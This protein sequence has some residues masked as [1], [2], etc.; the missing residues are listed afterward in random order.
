MKRECSKCGALQRNL[1]KP[2]LICNQCML[3]ERER[4]MEDRLREKHQD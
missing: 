3:E 2:N 4:A 1:W